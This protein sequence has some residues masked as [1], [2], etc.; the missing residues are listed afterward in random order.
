MG[1]T[2][3]LQVDPDIQEAGVWWLSC[4]F[5]HIMNGDRCDFHLNIVVPFVMKLSVVM[6]IQ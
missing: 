2:I 5:C 3:I 1:N 4:K 6:N